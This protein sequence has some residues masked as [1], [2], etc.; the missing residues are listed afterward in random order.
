MLSFLTT[1]AGDGKKRLVLV[2]DPE[3]RDKIQAGRPVMI[4]LTKQ[5]IP[6]PLVVVLGFTPSEEGLNMELKR[7]GMKN[8]VL[9]G[10]TLLLALQKCQN[11]SENVV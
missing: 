1:K 7:M 3:T 9:D 2:L 5:K 11:E 6:L 10:E 4:D 8:D